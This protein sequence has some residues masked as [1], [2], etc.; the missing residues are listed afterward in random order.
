MVKHVHDQLSHVN[1]KKCIWCKR[2]HRDNI[3]ETEFIDGDYTVQ[4]ES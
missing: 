1:L 3:A 2:E 4:M